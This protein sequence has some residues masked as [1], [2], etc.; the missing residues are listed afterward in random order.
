[1][2]VIYLNLPMVA[3]AAFGA[4]IVVVTALRDMEILDLKKRGIAASASSP[5]EEEEE[6]FFA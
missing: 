3:V 6:D 2:L 4:V 5:E 1:M